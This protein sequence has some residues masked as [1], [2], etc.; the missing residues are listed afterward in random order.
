MVRTLCMQL[1]CCCFVFCCQSW[2]VL[3]LVSHYFVTVLCT[4][5]H[6]NSNYNKVDSSGAVSQPTSVSTPCITEIKRLVGINTTLIQRTL[7]CP[8]T[9]HNMWECMEK[10]RPKVLFSI[11]HNAHT[12]VKSL[13]YFLLKSNLSNDNKI[14]SVWDNAVLFSEFL[15]PVFIFISPVKTF[16]FS[17]VTM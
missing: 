12:K 8:L 3:L 13:F 10:N 7:A 14:K 9:Q 1:F 11:L 5:N 4:V 6:N 17:K 15:P 16:F 2:L